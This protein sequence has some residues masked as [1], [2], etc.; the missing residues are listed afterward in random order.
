MIHGLRSGG[1]VVLATLLLGAPAAF[2]EDGPT[3]ARANEVLRAMT[4]TLAAAEHLRFHAEIEYDVLTKWGGKVLLSGASEIVVTRPDS[5]YVDFRDDVSA[6]RL[7]LDGEA[8]TILDPGSGFYARQPAR[9]E[10]DAAV[11]ELKRRSGLTLPLAELVSNDPHRELS[12]GVERAY[13][14]GIHDADGVAWHHLAFVQEE[15]DRVTV[16]LALWSGRDGPDARMREAIA[17]RVSEAMGVRCH[18]EFSI[19][20][21]IPPAPSGKHL[22]SVSRISPDA[23]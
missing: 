2:A 5:V 17:G 9:G 7:W 13:Y 16:R 10:I 18:V 15:I 3:P 22:Y 11:N 6:R 12:R 1:S 19:E 21:D 14:L 23:R 4:D 8:A 20:D